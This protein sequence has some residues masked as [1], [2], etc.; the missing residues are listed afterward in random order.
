MSGPRDDQANARAQ[1]VRVLLETEKGGMSHIALEEASAVLSAHLAPEQAA[2]EIRFLRRLVQGT[3]VR[4]MELDWHL[5]RFSRTPVHRMKPL[6]R[7]VLRMTVYQMLYMDRVPDSAA[8]SEAVKIIR[9]SRLS[10]LSGFVNGVLRS[11]GREE[12]HPQPPADVR[13]GIPGWIRDRWMRQYGPD[14]CARICEALGEERPLSV[15]FCPRP[16]EGPAEADRR[17][18][19][20][21]A[22]D[23]VKLLPAPFPPGAYF[24]QNV[25]D[26]KHLAAFRSGDIAVQDI[27]SITAG[28][29]A[30]P[31]P[32]SRI[33]D[34]CAA[35][36]GKSIHLA[37]LAGPAGSVTACDL[38]ERKAARIRE[39]AERLH[40]DNVHV[41]IQDALQYVP[42]WEKAFDL[43][44]CDLPCSG[45][46][47]MARKPEIRFRVKEE[48]IR[49]L[50]GLQ[51]KILKNAM[52]YVRPGG[53][54]MY[55]TC[56]ITEEENQQ[57][58]E[59]ILKAP[60]FSAASLTKVLPEA[61][62]G[63]ESAAEGWLQLLPGVYPCDGFFL[64]KYQRKRN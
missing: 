13:S 11:F 35:P 53:T 25:S 60:S 2:R 27:S 56:T 9:K 34:V 24:L 50:A 37:Q 3:L 30:S 41:L 48:E 1:A 44:F 15:R 57:N 10:G 40:A 47:V 19:A 62:R 33:L 18:G 59:F 21:L 45:L 54:L 8:V 36:G 20:S 52:R 14:I 28:L 38:S 12:P 17:I 31:Q 7:C 39:N 4:Q 5:D 29:A 6:I 49:E 43:V 26:L 58:R 42:E 22:A 51:K 61:L 32:G 16:G 64:S 55:T 23:G 63:E 46:G